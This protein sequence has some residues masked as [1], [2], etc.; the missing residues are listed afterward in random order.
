MA[1]TTD[2][3][4]VTLTDRN[5]EGSSLQYRLDGGA[6]LAYSGSFELTRAAYPT[7]VTL[8]AR[9]R[10]ASPAYLDSDLNTLAVGLTPVQLQA[11]SISSSSPNFRPGTSETISFTLTNPNPADSV[12]EYRLDSGEWQ[13]YASA[14]SLSRSSY[15]RR[16]G[17]RG[18]GP[19]DGP[20][21]SQ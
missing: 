16:T 19:C 6:W 5:S 3:V 11:P 8:E 4:T 14:F 7:G 10:S 20:S 21:L 9:A 1:G 13:V 15:P 18:A 17:S 2:S 12:V